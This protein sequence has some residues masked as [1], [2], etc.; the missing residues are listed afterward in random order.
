[1]NTR[2]FVDFGID[3]PSGAH[4]EKDV[5]CPQCSHTRK[6]KTDKCLSVNVDKGSWLCMHC[7]WSGGLG[8]HDPNAYGAPLTKTYTAPVV[9][10]VAPLS[11]VARD[12]FTKRGIPDWVLED[13]GITDGPEFCPGLEKRV[14]AL[15]FPYHRQG[16]IVHYKFRGPGKTFWTTPNSE[17]I[18]YGLD[19]VVGAETLAITEGEV[20]KLTIDAVQGWPCVSVPDGAPSADAKHYA[21]KFSFLDDPTTEA[22]LGAAKTIVLAVDM[23]APGNKLADELA[24][25][26]GYKRCR[27]V[28]WPDGCK[29]ANET[30]TKLGASA[31]Q[32]ALAAAAPWPVTGIV[33]INELSDDIDALYRDGLDRGVD[34]GWPSFD[35]LCRSRQGLL[36]IVTGIPSH[37]KSLF[38]DNLMVRL[39]ERHDWPFAICSPENQPLARHFANIAAIR[40]GKPFSDG[41]T[42]RM[43]PRELDTAKAW[44]RERISFVL[45]D[46]PVLERILDLVD[47]QVYRQGIR[48]LIVDPWN[49]LSHN[50]PSGVNITDFAS[51]FL[52]E[53]RNFARSR[54]VAVWLVA[55]PTK[56]RKGEDGKYPVPTM[57]D[58]SDSAHF[59][60]KAD[61]GFA[62]HRDP[63]DQ[64]GLTSVHIQKIRFRETGRVGVAQFRYDDITGQLREDVSASSN[65]RVRENAGIGVFA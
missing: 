51:D 17:R 63:T 34:A 54:T 46:E 53:L 20:D 36:T 56:L 29:D 47:V 22:I 26:L 32:Q 4:G 64:H 44:A 41:P 7:G 13:A 3:V 58:I 43:S 37:G 35:A 23:D 59:Y 21:S 65:G 48:G 31:V 18:L 19:D 60:A 15:R 62:V 28:R 52:R 49:E 55:H 24:R 5:L 40:M 30:L 25:R 39:I 2:T 9:R 57:Y 6:K 8:G 42:A 14:N 61:V 33:T 11:D 45:P 50:R 38:L 1:M 12:W 27:R 10:E 16:D